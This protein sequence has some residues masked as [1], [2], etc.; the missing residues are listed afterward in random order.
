MKFHHLQFICSSV[1]IT[2]LTGG[3]HSTPEKKSEIVIQENGNKEYYGTIEKDTVYAYTIK[4]NKGL[5]AVISN[6]GGTLLALWA[7]DRSG[8]SGNII[9]G[10]DSLA[11]YRQKAN[12]YFGA[13]IG[14]YANR[15]HQG[16]FQID[17]KTYTLALNNHGNALHGG[18]KGFD[19]IIWTVN[20]VND[21]SLALSYLSRDGEEGYPGNLNV[22]VVYTITSENGLMIDYTA[23]TDMKTPVNLTNHAYFNLSAG[24]DST[25]L[26]E[27]I[28][29]NANRY[30]PVNDSL[31]PTGQIVTV[32]KTP[33]N[34]QVIKKIGK[35][36]DQVKGGYDHNFVINRKDSGMAVAAE[37]YEPAS[38][39]RMIVK[40]T[41]PG[42][43]FYT[44]NFLDGTLTGDNGQKIVKHGAVC[45]ETQHFPDSPNQPSFPNTILGPGQTFHETTVYLFSVKQ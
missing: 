36:I 35:D 31:I 38:G 21:S 28:K 18:L 13:L 17:G 10:Y 44:G 27:E 4:N 39:R 26:S 30:T 33:F 24:K 43:Q 12:P 5:K 19:K 9:L 16:T 29:I 32:E 3:C 7:P 40:T 25:I 37:L 6:Y 15:I 11:G 23:L 42:I 8:N 34:F 1:L 2:V 22:K 20:S 14:R 41:Q 45:L